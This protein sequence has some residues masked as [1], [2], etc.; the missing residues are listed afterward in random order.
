MFK[1]EA[2]VEKKDEDHLE[3]VNCQFNV[4]KET[5]YR[6]LLVYVELIGINFQDQKILDENKSDDGSTT[7]FVKNTVTKEFQKERKK[8]LLN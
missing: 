2:C 4:V 1:I 3:I 6:S 7:S 8:G 5:F